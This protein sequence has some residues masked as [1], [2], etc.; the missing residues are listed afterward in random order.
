MATAR[1]AAA[2]AWDFLTKTP[3]HEGDR[4]YR[5]KG[6]QRIVRTDG[7]PHERMQ[8]K[9][10][11]GGRIWYAIIRSATRSEPNL[12]LLERVLHRASQ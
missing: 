10:T 6:D 12:V 5:L 3:D 7:Q 4:C 8:Y 2:E 11:G 9:P 1:N